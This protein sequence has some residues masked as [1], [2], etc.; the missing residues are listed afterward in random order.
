M[1]VTGDSSHNCRNLQVKSQNLSI[2]LHK[3]TEELNNSLCQVDTLIMVTR[4]G[5]NFI[6]TRDPVEIAR[7]HIMFFFNSM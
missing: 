6:F 1:K 2:I 4:R 3:K 5:H 7:Y